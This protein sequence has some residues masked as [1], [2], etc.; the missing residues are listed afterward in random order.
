MSVL[1]EQVRPHY[2]VPVLDIR[3]PRINVLLLCVGLGGREQAIEIRRVC[4]VLPMVLE[5]VDV[6]LP[7]TRPRPGC[8]GLDRRRHDSI[9][10]EPVTFAPATL[11]YGSMSYVKE[12]SRRND[13]SATNPFRRRRD[14]GCGDAERTGCNGQT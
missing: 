3:Q 1:G 4:L 6:D 8:G 5:G 11:V 12:P 9:S 13:E 10:P 7:D 2:H 14:V